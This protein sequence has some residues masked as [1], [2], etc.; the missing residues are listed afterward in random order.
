MGQLHQIMQDCVERAFRLYRETRAEEALRQNAQQQPTLLTGGMTDVEVDTTQQNATTAAMEET[1]QANEGSQPN[2]ASAP[3]SLDFLD[4]LFNHPPA[5][6]ENYQ[7]FDPSQFLVPSTTAEMSES[8]YV[9]ARLSCYC[10]TR[11]CGCA[12]D[13]ASSSEK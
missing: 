1:V 7:D 8:G 12:Q 5:L 6:D 4:T 9:S 3:A 2:V 13:Q 11:Q 10:F